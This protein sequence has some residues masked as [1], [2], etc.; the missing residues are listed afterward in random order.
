M[1]IKHYLSKKQLAKP[2]ESWINTMATLHHQFQWL[3]SDLLSSIVVVPAQGRPKEGV[4][5]KIV[6]K[7]HGMRLEDRRIS[8]L[9]GCIT[10]YI[11]I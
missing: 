3:R 10:F 6:D 9:S 5:P 1:L 7:I 2:R 8:Q 4:K 11:N